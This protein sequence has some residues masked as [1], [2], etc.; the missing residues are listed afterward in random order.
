VTEAKEEAKDFRILVVED[1]VGIGDLIKIH[2]GRKGY[3]VSADADGDRAAERLKTE[4]FDLLILD[5]RLGTMTAE[6]LVDGMDEQGRRI[7]FLI[8]T[9][10]GDVKTAVT[11]MKKGARDYLY[12][13]SEFLEF[14]P[15]VVNRVYEEL[16]TE[17]K[18]KAAEK[19]KEVM[20]GQLLQ[21]QKLEAVGVMAGGIAH[22]FN[23][24]LTVVLGAVQMAL[25]RTPPEDPL[26]DLLKQ[27]DDAGMRGSSLTRQLLLFSRGQPPQRTLVRLGTTLEEMT[28]M[29]RRLLEENIEI[30][31]EVDPAL[32]PF[33]A[34]VGHIE[35]VVMNLV[36]NARDAMPG[37]GRI[38]LAA[39]NVDIGEADLAA[40]P[41]RRPGKYVRLTVTDN[42][43]GMD[44][45]TIP[46]IFDAFFTTKEKGKGTGLGLSVVD[47]IVKQHGGWIRV[48]SRPGEGTS[49]DLY[50]PVLEEAQAEKKDEVP[51]TVDIKG[52]GETVVFVEDDVPLNR[53]MSRALQD[54][55]YRVLSTHGAQE[56]E[57]LFN[58]N[59]KGPILLL[60]DVVLPDDNGIA[61]AERLREGDSSLRVLLTSGYLDDKSREGLI[62]NKGF[63][64]LP[65]PYALDALLE[66]VKRALS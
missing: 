16:Q 64:F 63:G 58:E 7:P 12:K 51:P 1:D 31:V 40:D 14:L 56:A 42:G 38:V 43:A 17:R 65:K 23:N 27:A 54:N 21:R 20:Q 13:D 36:L 5:Y 29:L 48:Y 60:C 35:Q 32:R 15:A 52:A 6:T 39:S 18:L 53:F 44:E 25:A 4:R 37:G 55:G 19:E 28:R 45:A 10:L 11:M 24:V 49:F 50:F 66:A 26:H 3:D 47:G 9:A 57:R 30:R 22:D 46:K 61:L 8:M 33:L 34:D 2:L 62:K 59:R 41:S